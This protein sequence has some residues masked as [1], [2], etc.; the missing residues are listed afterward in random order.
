VDKDKIQASVKN[1]VLR[2]VLPKVQAAKTRKIQVK[3]EV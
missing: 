1:G 3:A 2:L